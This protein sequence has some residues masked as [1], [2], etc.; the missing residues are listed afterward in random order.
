[1]VLLVN[2]EGIIKGGTDEGLK[3]VRL[4]NT[5]PGVQQLY[6]EGKRAL[7]LREKGIFQWLHLV[8]NRPE[9]HQCHDYRTKNNGFFVIEFSFIMLYVILHSGNSV[10]KWYGLD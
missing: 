4:S 1:M 9:C 6:N 5:D 7:L 8:K 10:L 3:G 2:R